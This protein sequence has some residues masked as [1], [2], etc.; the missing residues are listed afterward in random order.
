MA[1]SGPGIPREARDNVLRRFYRLEGS[2][3]TPGS[4]LGLSLVA[5][6]VKL[7][8]AELRMEDNQ[9]G[10]RISIIFDMLELQPSR[11]QIP[12]SV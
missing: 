1:D 3:N 6:V 9:P 7:H 2:R 12:K 5:A 11:S 4:G 8:N 10:V